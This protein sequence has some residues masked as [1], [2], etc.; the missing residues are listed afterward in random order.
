MLTGVNSDMDMATASLI[1]KLAGAAE[2][3]P[4]VDYS[5][6]DRA[7]M[8]AA[9]RVA[10][11]GAWT[12]GEHQLWALGMLPSSEHP[13]CGQCTANREGQGHYVRVRAWAN[14]VGRELYGGE[15]ICGWTGMGYPSQAP[16]WDDLLAHRREASGGVS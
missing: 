11:R 8:H 13:P 3:A 15:C 6:T 10:R 5:D 1:V 7:L 14:E 4:L 12:L 16:A 2:A 9:G